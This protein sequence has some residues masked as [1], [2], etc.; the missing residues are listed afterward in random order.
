MICFNV[1]K[2]QQRGDQ[3]PKFSNQF[4]DLTRIP[5]DRT[6]RALFAIV[7]QLVQALRMVAYVTTILYTD[8]KQT[9]KH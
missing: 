4:S 3:K 6:P 5:G 2:R 1:I 9:H 7:A 8:H